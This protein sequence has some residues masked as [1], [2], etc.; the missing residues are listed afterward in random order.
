LEI[1]VTE[2]ETKDRSRILLEKKPED[3][4]ARVAVDLIIPE[5]VPADKKTWNEIAD[6]GSNVVRLHKAEIESRREKISRHGWKDCRLPR[7]N[8]ES[9]L[10]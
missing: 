3:K 1:Q 5:L 4:C 6:N 7:L 2:L 9:W 8:W 10:N